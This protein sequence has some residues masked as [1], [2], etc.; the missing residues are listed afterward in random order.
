MGSNILIE[1]LNISTQPKPNKSMQIFNSSPPWMKYPWTIIFF[2]LMKLSAVFIFIAFMLVS[3]TAYGQ[4]RISIKANRMPVQ[5]LFK[6]L[7]KQHGYSFFY[8]TEMNNDLPRVTINV[9]NATIDEILQQCFKGTAFDYLVVDKTVVIR[10][11]GAA[12]PTTQVQPSEMMLIMGQVLDRNKL[13]LS[14]VTIK[15]KGSSS[16]WATNNAGDFNAVI[17]KTSTTLQ[18][19]YIGYQNKEVAVAN[20][21]NALTIVLDEDISKLDEIQVI[22]YGTTSKR[23]NTGNITTINSKVIE[24]FPVTNVLEVLQATVPGMNISRTNGNKGSQY[25]VQIRGQNGLNNG[26][27][28]LPL[29]VID[30]IP[31]EGGGY[32]LQNG[33]LG[34]SS[35]F[36]GDALNFINPLDIESVSI[37]KDAD[38][39][40]IYGSRAANGVVLI[41][42]KKGRAGNTKISVN[43]SK[44]IARV[45]KKPDMLNLSQYLQM[46]RE[47]KR[48]DNAPINAFDYDINGTWDTTRNINY[49]DE[50]LGGTAHTTNA[51]ASISGGADVVQYLVSGNFTNQKNF[52]QQLGGNNR[53]ANLHFNISTATADKKFS[54]QLT[55]GYL[56]NNNTIP[57]HELTGNITLAPNAPKFYNPDGTLNFENGTFAN[58][59]VVKNLINSSPASNIT[60][61]MILS[62]KPVDKLEVKVTMGINKQQVN[63]FLAAPFSSLQPNGGGIPSSRYTYNN[64]TSWSVEPQINY[65]DKIG[66]GDINVTLGGSLQK[67]NNESTQLLVTGFSN[68][69]LIKSI[70]AGTSI[71]TRVP[72]YNVPYK[73]NALFGRL[74]YNQVGKYILNIS[75]RYDGS[76]RFGENKQFHFFGAAGAAWIFSEEA[77][78][79]SVLPVISFAKLR[80]SYGVTG[81]DQI[82]AYAY[83]ENYGNIRYPYQGLPGLEPL[84]IS[85]PDISWETTRKM[86][87]AIELQ[88]FKGLISLETAVYQNRTTDVLGSTPLSLVTGFS[89]IRG[90]LP[91]KVQN[92]G[93][94]ITLT[95][96]NIRKENFSWSSTLLFTRQ[97]NKLIEYPDL[98]RSSQ[99]GTLVIGQ[100]VN[101]RH[102]YR[103]AGVN[104]Q[105]GIYQFY[106]MNG[107][108]VNTPSFSTDRTAI[109]NINPDFFGSLNN[110]FRYK[111]FTLD[112][113]FRYIKQIG[114]NQFGQQ[115]VLPAGIAVNNNSTTFVLDRWQ[116]PGDIT[117]IQ[118]FGTNFSLV[119]SHGTATTSDRGY[120]DASYIR[121]QNLS[122]GYQMPKNIL[123]R[124]KVQ[125]LRLYIQ[126]ENLFTISKYGGIDPE[127]QSAVVLPLLRVLTTG[128][129]V[130]F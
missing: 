98:E 52:F 84:N 81:N 121:L 7:Q 14:G 104:Q 61:S 48:N 83:L 74:N 20:S 36:G 9:R 99:A 26:T 105:T 6:Q 54:A 3:V 51:Q 27:G 126:G 5:N 76:S 100:P 108:I 60:S 46:R 77:F 31:F 50:L 10:R 125:N 92:T 43:V 30:G 96:N 90:N 33:T 49:A 15:L 23:N 65:R 56:Y 4:A 32:N 71:T 73:F 95:A 25:N 107:K 120:G 91:G 55:G 93:I 70:S 115:T 109:I 18:L 8:N 69:A 117:D 62:Y 123:D 45:S 39:T 35:G 22:A 1:Q 72:Y 42:T 38:A 40:S 75:G 21:K 116:R 101:I 80:A 37:L 88:F 63:E 89:G 127:T 103:F 106:D 41:T 79:K 34:S 57:N 111:Q 28:T 113:L 44:G 110:S 64:N 16:Q 129:Q 118:R 11:K 128:L 122:L 66:T 53:T 130:T 78:F 59:L 2:R 68:D 85:N 47:A 124:L 82:G 12:V 114:R 102:V 67:K 13:P 119:Y 97:R 24:R 17:P 94:E 19:S 58:P 86:E 29:Y 112:V 87:S